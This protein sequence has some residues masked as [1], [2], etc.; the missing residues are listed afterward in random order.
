MVGRDAE[1][2]E[3]LEAF[4]RA[5]SG[6][7]QVA[8]VTGEAGIGKTRLVREFVSRLPE[9]AVVA[10]GHAVPLSGAGLAYSLAG[11]LLRS[12]VRAVDPTIVA[13]L[14]A[15]RARVLAPLV[16]RL[17]E[18]G[19]VDRLALLTATQDLLA[20]VASERAV[21]LVL[22]DVH[23][24][25]EASFDLVLFWARTIV[26]GRLLIIATLREAGLSADRL[27]RIDGL[28]RGAAAVQLTP[29]PNDDVAA[30]V[31]S[32]RPTA[33]LAQIAEVQRLSQ[34]L[35][36][37]VEA[38]A[39]VADSAESARA[40]GVRAHLAARLSSLGD[41][42]RHLLELAAHEPRPFSAHDLAAV[43]GV[44]VESAEG[45]VDTAAEVGLLERAGQRWRFR[46]E[47]LRLAAVESTKPS[48]G[49]AAHRAWADY[50]RRSSRADDLVAAADHH[51][52][53]GVSPEYLAARI[54]AAEAVWARGSNPAARAQWLQALVAVRGLSG[55]VP[56]DDLHY[57][58]GALGCVQV[59]WADVRDEILDRVTA[60]PGS[61]VAWHLRL[62][63]YAGSVWGERIESPPLSPGE[64]LRAQHRLEQ[65]APSFLAYTTA[66]NL[67]QCLW[68]RS[69][70]KGMRVAVRVA[71]RLSH[72]L[73]DALTHASVAIAEFRLF[74]LAG[75]DHEPARRALVEETVATCAALDTR[76][77]VW[78]RVTAAGELW[79]EG[80]FRGAKQHLR[81][82]FDLVPDL[83]VDDFW[84]LLAVL[85]SHVSLMLGEWSTV[86][87]LRDEVASGRDPAHRRTLTWLAGLVQARRG[88]PEARETAEQLRVDMATDWSAPF[89]LPDMIEAETLALSEPARARE[90]MAGHVDRQESTLLDPS[91]GHQFGGAWV[92]AATL[93]WRD[94]AE[95]SYRTA[96]DDGSARALDG[97]TL[98]LA[99]RREVLAHL[100]RAENRDSVDQWHGI[101]RR[102]DEMGA[103]YRA[104]SARLRVAELLVGEKELDS[105]GGVLA[106]ALSDAEA[107][108]AAPLAGEIRSLAARARLRLP[109][110]EPAM[111]D[112]G[113]LTAREYEVL[114]LLVQG[115]TNGQIGSALFMSPRTASVH[116][117]HILQ[118][119][120]AANRTEVA[121]VAHRRGLVTAGS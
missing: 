69:D 84:Y 64:L 49:V 60:P 105:A 107:L 65:E 118:K 14:L 63:R 91:N 8:V 98:G 73:P 16:P 58:L 83:E 40:T 24:A 25:D 29:L 42:H 120:G 113:P 115:M 66:F 3:L 2:A 121:V 21:V 108:G 110:H 41:E 47:L 33:T 116:V 100:A 30:H 70:Y 99:W 97:C 5:E 45:A 72:G 22:E 85:G 74:I 102:W 81:V 78:A 62:L 43:G 57:I 59:T 106:Q 44:L 13:N 15:G 56:E 111:G 96:L 52:A 26:T 9:G 76:S 1:L 23:W 104:A 6:E 119:L 95:E 82:G 88:L 35:P 90:L 10:F 75:L 4:Q 11:D 19:P 71:E 109:G 114:Q 46:H 68:L 67:L 27:H 79:G 53:L 101:V 20:D 77:R 61:L 28:R 112:T 92:L 12:L 55:D 38:L 50:L 117:S 51:E 7:A 89:D 18:S 17:G 80:D 48:A 36:L 39:D 103:R 31:R 32:L 93:A 37:F 87:R 54:R 86:L 94:Q 34:G